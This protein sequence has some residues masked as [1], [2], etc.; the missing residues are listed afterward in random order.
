[1]DN[2]LRKL[3]LRES[4]FVKMFTTL[5][6]LPAIRYVYIYAPANGVGIVAVVVVVRVGVKSEG[7]R[8]EGVEVVALRRCRIVLRLGR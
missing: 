4:E 5:Q 3:S 1:M 7:W 6:K 8:V 2:Q